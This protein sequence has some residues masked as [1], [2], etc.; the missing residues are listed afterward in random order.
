MGSTWLN[1]LIVVLFATV[2]G[3]FFWGYY[4]SRPPGPPR[5]FIARMPIYSTEGPGG[6][7]AEVMWF[8]DG[9]PDLIL[10][11]DQAVTAL[12]FQELPAVI[13]LS[14][15]EDERLRRFIEDWNARSQQKTDALD[16]GIAVIRDIIKNHPEELKALIL[17]K[18]A[19]NAA[20]GTTE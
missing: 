7:T 9:L 11:V 1:V 6:I 19:E 8:E 2:I 4:S 12:S 15:E 3:F 17:K 16:D 13:N 5:P 14:E 10:K 18:A 20:K